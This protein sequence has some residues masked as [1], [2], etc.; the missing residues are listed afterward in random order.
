M[1]STTDNPVDP[2]GSLGKPIR[3]EKPT[4]APVPV[5]PGVVR[6]ST[7]Q[8]ETVIAPPAPVWHPMP[9]VHV[10]EQCED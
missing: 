2:F 6:N 7:G 1:R 3:Q 10:D 8:L 5:A 9:V 4:A